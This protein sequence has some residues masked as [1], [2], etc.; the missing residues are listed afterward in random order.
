MRMKTVCIKNVCDM[1]KLLEVIEN[2]NGEIRYNTDLKKIDMLKLQTLSGEFAFSMMTKLWGG[3]E[4]I[5]LAIIRNLAIADLAA[6]VNRKEM[7]EFLDKASETTA[8]L[9]NKTIDEMKKSGHVIQ[10]FA[11]GVKP[12]KKSS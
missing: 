7:V 8:K 12:P 6:S 11:P 4:T 10:Y 3:N 1:K 9:L 5:V 2:E